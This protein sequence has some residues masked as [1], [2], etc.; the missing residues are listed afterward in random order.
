MPYPTN[1]QMGQREHLK[2]PWES[3]IEAYLNAGS[4]G[5]MPWSYG[6][7]DEWD[8]GHMR[9][10]YRDGHGG[11]MPYGKYA[12]A[13]DPKDDTIYREFIENGRRVWNRDKR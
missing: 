12:G 10:G 2:M 9:W 6:A 11:V 13:Y 1:R 5:P 4:P 3:E 8:Q 7:P